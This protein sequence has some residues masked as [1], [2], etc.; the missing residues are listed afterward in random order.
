MEE[1]LSKLGEYLATYGLKVVAAILIFI[2][3]RWVTAIIVNIVAR[4]MTKAAIEKTLASFVKHLVY[5]V[6]MAFVIV[7]A[8]NKLGVETA[9]FIAIIGAAGLAIGL[10]LQGALANF[11]AGVMLIFFK[12]FK[13][14][15]TVQVGGM[16]GT[17][18]ELQ[19]FSTILL[20]PDNRR[21][22]IPNSKITGDNITNYNDVKQRRVDVV[23]G[24]SYNDDLKKAKSI[25]EEVVVADPRVL[26]DP[27][28]GIVVCELAE[29]SVNIAVRPWVKPQDYWDVLSDV[30][31]RGKLALDK[32]G[33]NMPYPQ[34]DIHVYQEKK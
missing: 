13:V 2:I 4:V 12:P 3:G 15:D 19:I 1:I 28:P 11:A 6:L 5:G 8:L 30:L 9:S 23:F 20:T 10:A 26:K 25:L 7:A 24:I 21:I 34:R 16:T 14:G 27:K 17:V 22:I 31:E 33:I 29:S 18:E 32:N